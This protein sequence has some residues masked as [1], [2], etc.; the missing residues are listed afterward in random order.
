MRRFVEYAAYAL[1][2][3]SALLLLA[4]PA[5]AQDPLPPI[6]VG[7][8]ARVGAVHTE[9]ADSEGVDSFPVESVR[10]FLT[11][12]V[13]KQ[14]KVT[15]NTEYTG[16]SN[17]VHVMDAIARFEMSRAFNVWMGRFIPPSDRANLYGPY[18]ANHWNIFRDGVQDGYPFVSDGRANGVAWWGQFGKV[19][20]SG[21]VFDGTGITSERTVIK[22]ARISVDL[23]DPEPSYYPNGT[24]YGG[25]NILAFGVTTQFQDADR[26]AWNAD[27]VLERKAGEGGAWTVE[28]EYAHYDR[29]GGYDARYGSD[30]GGYVLAS[31]L[32]PRPTG[33]GRL[34]FLAKTGRATF[35][36]GLAA[37]ALDYTQ[38]TTEINVNYIIKAFD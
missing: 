2:A 19:S 8:G 24:Y 33:I 15:F 3:C 28:G 14:I 7:I 12:G 35:S 26:T 34:Q 1:S 27:A 31:Y 4:A 21:G 32:L 18:F 23:W 29:L 25:K 30:S 9:P 6:S 10:L 13:T 20:A 16:A 36:D 5:A 38:R 37:S 22:A 17:E 11:G